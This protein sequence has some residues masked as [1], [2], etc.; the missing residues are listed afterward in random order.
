M[1]DTLLSWLHIN[2]WISVRKHCAHELTKTM[3]LIELNSVVVYFY[4]HR[5]ALKRRTKSN[6]SCHWQLFFFLPTNRFLI[7]FLIRHSVHDACSPHR[8]QTVWMCAPQRQFNLAFTRTTDNLVTTEI[9]FTNKNFFSPVYS[10]ELWIV[11][12]FAMRKDSISKRINAEH[13]TN[14]FTLS[15]N[16]L[17][18]HAQFL[19]DVMVWSCDDFS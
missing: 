4:S 6:H 5:M 18:T 1:F 8:L 11:G 15:H 9:S 12:A 14:L 7:I 3:Q 16:Y 10:N 19:A 2:K 13:L 17:H